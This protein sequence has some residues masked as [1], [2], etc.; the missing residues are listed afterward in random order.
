MSSETRP[1]DSV[2]RRS[3]MAV[4]AAISGGVGLR[5]TSAV[6]MASPSQRSGAG[7][8][9]GNLAEDL[10]VAHR[11][12]FQERVLDTGGHVSVRRDANHFLAGWRRAPE[13]ITAED[14]LEHDLDGKVADTKGHA[15]NSERF[16]HAEI[17]RARPDVNAVVHAHTPA[18]ILFS[19]TGTPMEPILDDAIFLGAGAPIFKASESGGGANNSEV[20]RTVAQTLGKSAVV[21]FRGHGLAVVGSS[22]G[23]VIQRAKY[24]NLN[25]QLQAQALAMGSKPPYLR[26][27]ATLPGEDGPPGLGFEREWEAWRRRAQMK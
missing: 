22:L 20:G 18:V 12:L 4:L 10:A 5:G 1:H 3:F 16:I 14:I 24:L 17:Y 15:L 21:L 8:A 23:Q 7:P 6:A 9:T 25:A 2:T 26:A 27:P 19:V 11:I 13:L